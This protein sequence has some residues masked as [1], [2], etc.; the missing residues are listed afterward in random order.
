MFCRRRALQTPD[1]YISYLGENAFHFARFSAA[2]VVVSF[3]SRRRENPAR[4]HQ[5]PRECVLFETSTFN[6][7]IN[8]ANNSQ[9][10]YTH[11]QTER[12][13]DVGGMLVYLLR[14]MRKWR[15]RFPEKF[16][17]NP[18]SGNML[19]E[20]AAAPWLLLLLLLFRRG[21]TTINTRKN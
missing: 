21:D 9:L 12:P 14:R 20:A 15:F 4:R 1:A 10:D 11:S 18:G 17:H 7:A 16:V 2:L 19:G 3:S 5:P 13:W 8:Y 6:C